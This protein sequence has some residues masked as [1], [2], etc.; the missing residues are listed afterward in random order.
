VVP[1]YPEGRSRTRMAN[2]M[3]NVIAK[4]IAKLWRILKELVS[5]STKYMNHFICPPKIN[6]GSLYTYAGMCCGNIL[7]ILSFKKFLILMSLI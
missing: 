4:Y 7:N 5:C 3:W 2:S 6:E 1:R